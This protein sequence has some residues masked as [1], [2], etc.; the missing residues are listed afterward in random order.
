MTLWGGI[1]NALHRFAAAAAAPILLN[2][3]MMATPCARLL[4][5][6]AGYAAAWGVLISGVLQ[7][8][9]LGGDT[10]RAGAMTW[11]RALRWDA[12]DVKRFFEER[13]FRRRS[14]RR[15]RSLRCSPIPSSQAC[16]VGRR[17]LGAVLCRPH[18]PIADWCHRHCG[19]NGAAAGNDAAACVRR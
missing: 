16:T 10:L 5:P 14:D 15:A 11:F 8:L 18:R 1:L 6:G 7:A 17:N 13:S 9:L 19:R 3:S 4:F 2:V 12:D